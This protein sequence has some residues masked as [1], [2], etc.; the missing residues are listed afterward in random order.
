MTT[1]FVKLCQLAITHFTE[2]CKAVY[3]TQTVHEPEIPKGYSRAG[4]TTHPVVVQLIALCYDYRHLAAHHAQIGGAENSRFF[5]N[6]SIGLQ[7]IAKTMIRNLHGLKH[8]NC[9]LSRLGVFYG[10]AQGEQWSFDQNHRLSTWAAELTEIMRC[11][12]TLEPTLLEK[13]GMNF[14]VSPTDSRVHALHELIEKVKAVE[15]KE[16]TQV[17]NVLLPL[18]LHLILATQD[19]PKG[20]LV[21]S[22]TYDGAHVTGRAS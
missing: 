16:K 12:K 8:M 19:L 9:H 7:T 18:Q 5:G 22:V 21:A 4:M 3:H 17:L 1:K 14:K 11:G 2:A 15:D 10:S 6:V 20:T 13:T